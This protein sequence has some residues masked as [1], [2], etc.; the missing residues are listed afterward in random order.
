[1]VIANGISLIFLLVTLGV[2]FGIYKSIGESSQES[3]QK[4]F[5]KV[6]ENPTPKGLKTLHKF[7]QFTQCC[8]VPLPL[9]VPW[10][11]SSIRLTNPWS[12]WFYYT[13]LDEEYIPEARRLFTL[14]WSCCSDQEASCEH[15]AFERFSIRPSA[16]EEIIDELV[17]VEHRLLTIFFYLQ[18]ESR[19][20]VYFKSVS[21]L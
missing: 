12:S 18:P 1:M 5:L 17:E 8:G 9:D 13:I 14:P 4:E 15:L 19:Y 20:P 16:K 11:Q 7:Q 2:V 3:F 21:G 10:N 6:L